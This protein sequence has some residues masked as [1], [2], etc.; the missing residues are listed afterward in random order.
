MSKKKI[1]W[2]IIIAV[3]IIIIITAAILIPVFLRDN[4]HLKL[5]PAIVSACVVKNSGYSLL[6]IE[7]KYSRFGR[8]IGYI[9]YGSENIKVVDQDNKKIPADDIKPGQMINFTIE[10]PVLTIYPSVYTDVT[11]IEVTSHINNSL[12]EEGL[13]QLDDLQKEGDKL[14]SQIQN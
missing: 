10:G 14:R 9:H 11:K 7:E 3:I 4:K 1:I 5:E 12:C 6:V 2:I 13:K 8:E